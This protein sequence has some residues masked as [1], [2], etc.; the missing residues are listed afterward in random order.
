MSMSVINDCEP[1]DLFFCIGE[2]HASPDG[3]GF[4]W[5][6]SRNFRIGERLRYVGFRQNPSSK[7]RPT[8]WFVI[9]ETAD[10]KKYAATQTY[11]VTAEEWLGLKK[12]FT[13]RLLHEP[14]K[15][16]RGPMK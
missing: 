8:G 1:G 6:T 9:F 12:Y 15:K 2:F 14:K 5:D 3:Q 7:D 16:R 10:K 11:F 4:S 13:R